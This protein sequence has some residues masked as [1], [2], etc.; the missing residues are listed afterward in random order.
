MVALLG[1]AVA[2][3]VAAALYA[4]VYFRRYMRER[5]DHRRVVTLFSRYVPAPVVEELLAR[6]DPRLFTAREYYATILCCRIHN[7]ALFCESLTAEETLTYL[8]EFYTIVG[9]A[10]Q[11]N[12][13]MIE[14]L[15]GD[16]V[17]AVFG[18]L[19][20]ET[21]QEERALRAA[22]DV[23]RMVKA[24]EPRWAAQERRAFTVGIGVNSGKIVAG[25]TG[26]QHRREFAVVGNPADVAI[27][28]EHASEELNATVVASESTYDPVRELFVGVPASSIPLRGLRRLQNA[29]VVRGLSRRTADDA[30]T[31]PQH[32]F[33]KTVVQ[34]VEPVEFAVREPAAAVPEP[35]PPPEPDPIVDRRVA[36]PVAVERVSF[37]G[38]EPLQAPPRFSSLDHAEAAL[39]EPP[40]IE[41]YED[42]HGPPIQLPP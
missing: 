24:M 35:P 15:R 16:M 4:G 5:E 3:A 42:D 9:K 39:P 31:L 21:F 8:N 26:F 20:E 28:L 27:R 10:V 6:G 14:S 32:A 41:T 7:F 37:A 2:A 34:P 38:I 1:L 29:Y 23:M 22:L 17:M 18:V 19:L 40:L 25:D 13:G 12:H 30:L 36:E 11:R 33:K